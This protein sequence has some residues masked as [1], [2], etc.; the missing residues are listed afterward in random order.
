[1][2]NIPKKTQTLK[3]AICSSSDFVVPIIQ[4]IIK[5]QNKS[6]ETL[7]KE[8]IETIDSKN[9]VFPNEFKDLKQDFIVELAFVVT[10]P[11]R[12]N[13]NQTIQ[14]DVKKWCIENNIEV[15]SPDRISE[16]QAELSKVDLVITASFGQ[17]IDELT[18][19]KPK[20]GWI[21]WHPSLLPAYRGATPLQSSII[22]QDLNYGLSWIDVGARMDE[23]EV[24]LQLQIPANNEFYEQQI[25]NMAQ[26][27]ARTWA[28]AIGNKMNSTQISQAELSKINNQRLSY[29]G[30]LSKEDGIT[31][32]HEINAKE[33]SAK[34]R[35][36]SVYPGIVIA[37]DEVF[38][39]FRIVEVESGSSK[40]T[41]N[42]IVIFET[43]NWEIIK[44]NKQQRIF[45]KCKDQE[46]LEIKQIKNNNGK[47]IKLKNYQFKL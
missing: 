2:K 1:M 11:D 15:K 40:N 45:L 14:S 20:I 41:Q 16:I 38:G 31:Y 22:N 19:T 3:I 42:S 23:G 12:I 21:N 44:E 33:L 30:R 43:T 32:N 8:Q 47:L 13:R 27:G 39:D 35:A 6:L 10:Q 17:I 25:Q 24:Y 37:N 9:I 46:L 18:L 7:Y 36:L 34:F 4:S 28:V 29:Y 5:E 26:I